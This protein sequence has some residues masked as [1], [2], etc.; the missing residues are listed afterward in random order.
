MTSI[1]DGKPVFEESDLQA[2]TW[3]K[4]KLLQTV[5]IQNYFDEV[6]VA[7]PEDG[8]EF[9]ANYGTEAVLFDLKAYRNTNE[10]DGLSVS[11]TIKD[12]NQKTYFMYCTDEGTLRFQDG[13]SP[14]FI[15]GNSSRIIFYQRHFTQG[16]AIR[17]KFESALK[18]GYYLAFRHEAGKH[19]LVMKPKSTD[20]LDDTVQFK[21]T[22]Q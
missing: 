16:D 3:K 2:D 22:K 6:L 19:K 5:I 4:A 8:A 14:N 1:K 15:E 12:N 9:L 11:F 10:G 13:D 20:E 7:F 21:L 18:K 17:F